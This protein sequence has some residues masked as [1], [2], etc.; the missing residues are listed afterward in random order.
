MVP[1][2]AHD[3]PIVFVQALHAACRC[4]S[5]SASSAFNGSSIRMMSAPP[6]GQHAAVGGGEPE[7]PAGGQ[8]LLHRL[9]VGGKTGREDPPIP[10]D[11]STATGSAQLPIL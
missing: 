7:F 10:L 8:E 9:A 3:R 11:R 1:A 4:A 5:E 2:R 6:P